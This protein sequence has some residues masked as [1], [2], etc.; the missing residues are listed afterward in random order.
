LL[1]P[2]NRV[3]KLV[4]FDEL[5]AVHAVAVGAE[6]PGDEGGEVA[7]DAFFHEVEFVSR[8]DSIAFDAETGGG[9]LAPDKAAC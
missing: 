4:L 2:K 7:V 8:Y 5:L 6:P 3:S 9:R 1:N